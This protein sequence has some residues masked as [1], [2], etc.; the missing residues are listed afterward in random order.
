MHWIG[1]QIKKAPR[2]KGLCVL[3]CFLCWVDWLW[4]RGGYGCCGMGDGYPGMPDGMRQYPGGYNQRTT[5]FL[6]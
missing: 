2:V 5:I 6:T 1:H 4:Y 3:F